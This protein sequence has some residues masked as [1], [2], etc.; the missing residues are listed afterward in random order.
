MAK[1]WENEFGTRKGIRTFGFLQAGVE[2]LRR[3]LRFLPLQFVLVS[4]IRIEDDVQIIDNGHK[5]LGPRIPEE[6]C[7]LES[8]MRQK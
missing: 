4:G 6:P 7:E 3:T 1:T 2:A 8:M 5:V